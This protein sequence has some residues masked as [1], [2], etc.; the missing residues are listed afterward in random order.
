MWGW[1]PLPTTIGGVIT[2]TETGDKDREVMSVPKMPKMNEPVTWKCREP[3]TWKCR[4]M[5]LTADKAVCHGK[6]A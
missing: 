6:A 4:D 2:D 1:H 5:A 3:V